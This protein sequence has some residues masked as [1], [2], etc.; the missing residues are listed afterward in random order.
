MS[1]E[2]LTDYKSALTKAGAI[3]IIPQGNS[4][5]PTLKHKGQSVLIECK[6]GRLQ[7]F[8]VALYLVEEKYVLHRILKVTDTG[9]I[10]CGDAMNILEKVPEEN[11]IG[12]MVGFYRKK[13]FVSCTDEDYIK[14]VKNWYKR[15]KLRKT[16][17]FFFHVR[18]RIKGIFRKIFKGKNK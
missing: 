8:D 17:L 12:K 6:K 1:I 14:K 2:K 18:L 4:M 16:R 11:V 9:Y 10:T 15:R 13:D 5:W 3:S 7:P